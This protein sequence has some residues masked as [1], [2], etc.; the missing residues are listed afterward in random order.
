MA[1]MTA[2]AMVA[3]RDRATPSDEG[4]PLEI[5]VGTDPETLDPRHTTDAM[6]L[7]VSRLVHAG[8]FR[9]D[10]DTLEPVHYVAAAHRWEDARTL[11]VDLRADV[12]F[13]SGKP[14]EAADVVASIE[15][16]RSKTVASR[17]ARI[18]EPIDS[19]TAD[20]PLRVRFVLKRPHAT[21]LS[22]L[23]M[24]ILRADEALLGPHPLGDLDG[25]GPYT[26]G[27]AARGDVLLVPA[28]NGAIAKPARAIRVRTVRDEN[29]RALRLVAKRTD[30]A[31]N[32]VSPSLL[33]ALEDEPGLE[34]HGRPG[35]NITYM[36]VRTDVGP[37]KE[38]EVRRALSSGI[39]RDTAV[40]SFFLGRARAASSLL[41]PGHW[42]HADAPAIAYDPASARARLGGRRVAFTL[43]TTPDRLRSVLA[44]WAA[45]TLSEAGFD[46]EVIPLEFG[47]LVA[48]LNAGQFD[49][50]TLQLPELGEP[51]VLRVFLHSQ[52]QPPV[53]A[54]RGHVADPDIDA[55][56]DEGDA[57]TD[58]G[59]RRA[60]YAKLEA[61]VR[62]RLYLVPL[63]HEDQVVVTGPRARG[64]LPSADGRWLG[65]AA[66]R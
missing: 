7:R 55:A 54:N 61:L 29:A 9:L 25:C 51:N 21:L 53:G 52:M 2:C 49:A 45:Q 65:L 41:P 3:C 39:D 47:A 62:E 60:A 42:A 8:L 31:I 1:L 48:R 13:H 10:S 32:V 43:L 18:V 34:V 12:R 4:A 36:V 6:G 28:E 14:V 37:L 57:S 58:T 24:P 66:L 46:V 5:V 20:G 30:A 63:W 38:V 27:R 19:V 59:V 56:L 35:A 33:P 16:I 50:A 64:F 23:E 22:D 40:R 15:A 44:R 11:V 26:I 17:H